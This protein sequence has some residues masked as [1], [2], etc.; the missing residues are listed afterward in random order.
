MNNLG[1]KAVASLLLPHY[2]PIYLEM[3]VS[4]AMYPLNPHSTYYGM[5]YSAAG[6]GGKASNWLN[7]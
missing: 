3:A 1:K 4:Q 7:L 6:I 2:Q 5:K